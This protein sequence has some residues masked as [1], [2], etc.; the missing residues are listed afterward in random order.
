MTTDD[1]DIEC[2]FQAF[3]ELIMAGETYLL[4]GVPTQRQ[5]NCYRAAGQPYTQSDDLPSKL[6]PN[7]LKWLADMRQLY[8]EQNR[9]KFVRRS[10]RERQ[11]TD[12]LNIRRARPSKPTSSKIKDV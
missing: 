12:K 2:Q 11:S 10:I 6:I 5:L 1:E 8:E 7:L 4:A 9:Y 3:E